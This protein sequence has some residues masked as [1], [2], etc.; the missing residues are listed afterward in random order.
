MRTVIHWF[1]RDL[2]LHDN[3]ALLE[4]AAQAD[5]LIPLF[6]FDEKLL[7]SGRGGDGP[8]VSFMLDSL[9]ALDESLRERGSRLCIR[10]G[11]PVTVLREL[12]QETGAEL[13]TFNRDYSPYARK[14][15]S[16]VKKALSEA[17]IRVEEQADLVLHEPED[18]KTTEGHFYRVYTP[19]KRVWLTLSKPQPR[20]L[21]MRFPPAPVDVGSL[22]SAS[23]GS[24]LES[25]ITQAGEKVA[26]E[27]LAG[28]IQEAIAGYDEGRNLLGEK[29]TSRLSPHLRWGT[30]SVRQCYAA[31]S[32]IQAKGAEVWISELAWRDFFYTILYHKPQVIRESFYERF[33][34]I[35]WRNDSMYFA[36]WQ[37]GQT[38]YPVVDAAMRE[39]QATGWMH[40]RARMIAASFLC[41]DLLIDWRW[42]E[43]YFMQRLID[44]DTAANNGNWQWA[45]GTGVDAAPYFR[46]FN[47]VSQGQKF[48]PKG[49]YI[50]R[51][52]PEL[53]NVP[54][55]CIHT[56][57]TLP[58]HEFRATRY[59]RR[60]VDHAAQREKALEMYSVVRQG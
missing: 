31:A 13:V 58:D 1:R 30:I 11:S 28:F 41:K 12:A 2:R 37:T 29:L 32:R 52:I 17:G 26:R 60:I 3:T 27:Q 35:Q 23:G 51:W 19:Y 39:L 36:A 8:R 21:D 40:N 55:Q 57:W 4:A 45:A 46:I 5:Q 15:D 25:P 38:G 56:P 6:I 43:R 24:S 42:G 22:P 10:R 54:D 49:V 14:R 20:E 18:I 48:D 34:R 44:G 50:R 33:D 53:E 7:R 9:R 59:P 16:E 47:P